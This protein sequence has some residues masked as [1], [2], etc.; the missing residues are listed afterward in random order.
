MDAF[1]RIPARRPSPFALLL[2]GA[3]L[4]SAA[5]T[6]AHQVNY[7]PGLQWDSV[8]YISIAR[9]LRDGE[10]F[11]RFFGGTLRAFPPL[12]PLLLT[13]ASLGVFDPH[14]V[15]GPLNAAIMGLTVVIVGAWL[16]RRLE[17]QLL[18]AWGV[19]AVALSPPLLWMASWAMSETT[20]IL[21]AALALLSIAAY[22]DSPRRSRLLAAAALAALA[23]L[24]SYLGVT[25]IAVGIAMLLFRRRA[26]PAQRAPAAAV[27]A[28]IAAA[29]A[30]L[31]TLRTYLLTGAP[32]G[33]RNYLR[34]S[35]GDIWNVIAGTLADAGFLLSPGAPAASAAAI[36]GGV[37]LA[38]AAGAVAYA[39]L[40][41]FRAAS[42]TDTGTG[43]GPGTDT[44]TGSEWTGRYLLLIFAGFALA[45]AAALLIA[46]LFGLAGTWGNPRRLIA[47]Y[48]PLLLLALL[49]TDRALD[50]YRRRPTPRGILLP[51]FLLPA[52]ALVIIGQSVMTAR[53]ITLANADYYRTYQGARWTNSAALQ[54]IRAQALTGVLFSNAAAA[55]YIHTAA[56]IDARHRN[57]P[58]H[59]AA[60]PQRLSAA[61]ANAAPVHIV[62]FSDQ[63]RPGWCDAR[64]SDYYDA[65]ALR[66]TPG[67]ETIHDA[68]DGVIFRYNPQE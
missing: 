13:A 68:P 49:A 35:S 47:L 57:M 18:A 9:S 17:S 46:M 51:L 4:L 55:A 50:F 22:L 59:L 29:P 12:Y 14:A 25:V 64:D 48:L 10:G 60:L 19:L 32:T 42:G 65:A 15:A 54:Y 45:Y 67:L 56:A 1:R 23:S 28:L 63:G 62:W 39:L 61:R 52:L 36:A 8:E 20:F 40:Q 11:T 3:A 53:S 2:A 16:R 43:T 30:A 37:I 44:G 41:S 33:D 26:T 38:G 31:W 34:Y 5:L 6:L 58:C 7:G 66:A 21:L 24:T 27:Y